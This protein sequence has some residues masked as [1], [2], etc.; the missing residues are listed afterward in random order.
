MRSMG[1]EHSEASRQARPV[2]TRRRPLRATGRAMGGT[3]RWLARFGV[4]AGFIGLGVAVGGF[5]RFSAAV[6]EHNTAEPLAVAE[7]AGAARGIVVLTGGAARIAHGLSLLDGGA[8]ERL[9]ISGVYPDTSDAALRDRNRPY[10]RLFDCCI[11]MERI[12]VDTVSNARETARWVK[13]RGFDSLLLVTSAYHMPRSLMEFRRALP[14]VRLTAAP[15]RLPALDQEDWWRDSG[16]LRLVVGEY[17]KYVGALAR[18]WLGPERLSALRGALFQ[19][20]GGTQD[21]GSRQPLRQTV[22]TL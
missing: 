11:D 5:M 19:A 13:E 15:L 22:R 16:T 8:G 18:D 1:D 9:L 6:H 20:R 4:V 17:V 12:S 7:A 14:K 21:H 10:A 3:L 2:G